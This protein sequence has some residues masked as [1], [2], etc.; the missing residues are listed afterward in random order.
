[1]QFTLTITGAY[2]EF[3]DTVDSLEG[4]RIRAAAVYY[5]CYVRITDEQG[6]HYER[7]GLGTAPLEVSA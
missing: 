6:R 5:D 3:T 2:G 7:Y 4:A 1:M